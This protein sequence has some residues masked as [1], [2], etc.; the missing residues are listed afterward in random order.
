MS[1]LLLSYYKIAT[2]DNSIGN[3]EADEILERIECSKD[4]D[5]IIRRLS[6]TQIIACLALA[7]ENA[8]QARYQ[9]MSELQE[10]LAVSHCSRYLN[11][12]LNLV[13]RF[14]LH[15]LLEMLENLK[16]FE[17]GII[18]KVNRLPQ[19]QLYLQYGKLRLFQITF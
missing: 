7:Q 11:I 5:S 8:I 17:L 19:G 15:F 3:E 1:I 2:D 10:E 18:T 4:Q 6:R 16:L 14:R 12:F 9:V 13:F